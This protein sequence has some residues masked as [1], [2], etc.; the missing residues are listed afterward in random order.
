M[1]NSSNSG[2]VLSSLEGTQ[3]T[4]NSPP[5][6]PINFMP[7]T[8]EIV[9]E[10]EEDT[11][12]QSEQNFIDGQGPAYVA[13]R[14]LCRPSGAQ[15]PF[16]FLRIY[17]QIPWLGTELRKASVRA[18]QATGPF[19][20]PELQALKHFKQQGCN[21]IPE[22]LAYQFEKQDKEDIIPGGFVTYVIWKK[23]PGEPLDF[24]RFWNC[25][26]SERQNIRVKFRHIYEHISGFKDATNRFLNKVWSD[27]HYVAHDLVLANPSILSY[28]PIESIDLYRDD[29]GWEW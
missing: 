25:T 5:Q 20:P 18:A 13:G 27:T 21:V 11:V 2:Q 1:S 10:I 9:E 26:F 17:Q 24:T 16:A 14:F 23:V 28:F 19:E 7:E 4:M 22:L 15:G 3:I 8:W 29:N 12:T 6:P